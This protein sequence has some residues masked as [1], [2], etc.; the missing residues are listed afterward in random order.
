[1]IRCAV[2][3]GHP[4][5]LPEVIQYAALL[6]AL[7]ITTPVVAQ[8]PMDGYS[9]VIEGSLVT[10]GDKY[11]TPSILTT[12]TRVEV[13]IEQVDVLVVSGA[14]SERQ[15]LMLISKLTRSASL[16]ERQRTNAAIKVLEQFIT[17][18]ETY[19]HSGKVDATQG[20][21]LIAAAA[22]VI[23]HVDEQIFLIRSQVVEVLNLTS[24]VKTIVTEFYANTGQFPTNNAAAGLP[25]PEQL[26]GHYVTSITVK[27]GA[28]HIVF[29]NTIATE[30]AGKRV[31]LR[32]A[33]V[34]AN[35][36]LISWLCG[37][38]PP[39]EGMTAVG[40]NRTSVP[41]SYLPAS[42]GG[43]VIDE[44]LYVVRSQIGEALSLADSARS[45]VAEFYMSTGLFPTD[46]DA[47]GL[48]QPEQLSSR[49]VTSITVTDGAVLIAL[50]SQADRRITGKLLSI[51]PAAIN[52]S[53]VDWLCGYAPPPEGA[54]VQGN[55][56]TSVAAIYLPEHCGG[57]IDEYAS[58]I[59]S[60]ITEALSLADSAKKAVAEFY[61]STGMFPVNN[62]VVGLPKPEHLIGNYVTSIT[63][64]NGAIHI[65]FG[66]HAY[67]NVLAG[68]LLSIRPAIAIN[69]SAVDWLCG[70]AFPPE[71]WAVQGDN[72][73]S[74]P[75]IHLPDS[76][77]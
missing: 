67:E 59:Q 62:E 77:R 15:G 21:T 75:L 22:D 70:Y 18:V 65:A 44:R 41:A 1:M 12:A 4:L 19:V 39:A 68:Q 45:A 69:P 14:L 54:T 46:N 35:P 17:N 32:P 33:I 24:S 5:A 63:V 76:C 23:V 34:S 31:S 36:G 51:R 28:L 27:N 72:R 71:G 25:E 52:P 56:L 53:V 7:L 37:Y 6:A 55:N 20:K 74:V 10:T 73:T 40:K 49:Y 8:T 11:A 61:T 43:P 30:L 57:Y 3:P 13:I 64:Q 50:G 58:V 2:Y 60:Q 48:P 9:Q 38:L 16:F 29:G 66:S 42:C 47:A 26:S